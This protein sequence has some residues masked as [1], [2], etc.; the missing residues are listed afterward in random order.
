MDINL[1]FPTQCGLVG[2]SVVLWLSYWDGL[3]KRKLP[4]TN[5]IVGGDAVND[6]A[7]N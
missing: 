5:Q 7:T 2:G 3:S 1:I 6:V 4:I